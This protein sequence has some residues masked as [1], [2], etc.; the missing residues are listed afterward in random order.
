MGAPW[1]SST[2]FWSVSGQPC[3]GKRGVVG[4]PCCGKRGVVGQP[5]CGNQCSAC[6]KPSIHVPR[7]NQN[8]LV[9]VKH[10]C[11]ARSVLCNADIGLYYA[12]HT[13]TRACAWVSHCPQLLNDF[14]VHT[15]THARTH[16]CNALS[17]TLFSLV[18]LTLRT[19][20]TF[21]AMCMSRRVPS[22]SI[23]NNA[24]YCKVAEKIAV[25][26]CSAAEPCCYIAV[27]STT[28]TVRPYRMQLLLGP[29]R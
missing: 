6:T 14:P 28:C 21:S 12:A 13:S 15:H 16:L 5:C 9:H 11:S 4:Q 8:P 3:C 17:N 26:T 23:V 18:S 20:L 1:D 2:S 7:Q 24:H 10:T 27:L 25:R 19:L 22:V 29:A